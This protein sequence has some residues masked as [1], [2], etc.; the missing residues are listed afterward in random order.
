M[1]K[2]PSCVSIANSSNAMDAWKVQSKIK[3]FNYSIA[4]E[5]KLKIEQKQ[6]LKLMKNTDK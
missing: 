3:M 4:A 1:L 2:T 6:A 5:Q